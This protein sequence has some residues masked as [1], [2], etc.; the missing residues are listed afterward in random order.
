MSDVDLIPR[1]SERCA[2]LE[3]EQVWDPYNCFI[4]GFGRGNGVLVGER[5]S[6][7]ARCR[8]NSRWNSLSWVSTYPHKYGVPGIQWLT[9]GLLGDRVQAIVIGS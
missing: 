7:E 3:G 4:G 2:I 6:L 1:W 8:E 5:D 9:G